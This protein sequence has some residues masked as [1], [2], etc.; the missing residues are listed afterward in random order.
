M[1]LPFCLF[2]LG[3]VVGVLSWWLWP[4]EE[5]IERDDYEVSLWEER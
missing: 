5:R 1:I 4:D 3:S 2:L